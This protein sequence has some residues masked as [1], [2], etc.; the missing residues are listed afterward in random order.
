MPRT[1]SSH[2]ASPTRYRSPQRSPARRARSEDGS[3]YEMDLDALGMNSTFDSTGL[4]D[5]NA[6]RLD[7]VDSSDIEGPEDFTM[8]MTYWMTADLPLSQQIKSRKEV[9]VRV[10]EVSSDAKSGATDGQ[11]TTEEGDKPIMEEDSADKQS[12]TYNSGSPTVRANGTTD[13]QPDDNALSEFSMENEEKVMSYLSALPDSELPLATSTP[14]PNTLQV[15]KASSKARSL[16]PTVEDYTDTP[17]KPTQ[18]TVIHHV[19]ETTVQ[20]PTTQL[21]S[22]GSDVLRNLISALEARL[23]QREITSK[24]RIAELETILSFTRSEL[25]TARTEGYRQKEQLSVLREENEQR[26]RSEEG[27]KTLLETKLR[28]QERESNARMQEL[29]EELHLQN[30]AKLQNQQEEFERQLRASEEGRRS[31]EQEV[32]QSQHRVAQLQLELDGGS[33]SKEQ[34]LEDLK[35]THSAEQRKHDEAF[36]QERATLNQQLA[37]VQARADSL[38]VELEN[39]HHS[40]EHP[41][42]EQEFTVDRA[43]LNEKLFVL[44]NRANTLQSDLE[45]ANAEAQSAR[46]EAAATAALNR[47]T[48]DSAQTFSSRITELETRLHSL[49]S[50][51]NSSLSDISAKDQQLLHQIEDQERLEQQLNTAQGRIEGLETTISTLRQQLS[52]SHREAAKARTNAERFEREFEDITER[53]HDARLEADRR[54]ADVEKKLSKM[55]EQGIGTENRFKELKSEHEDVLESHTTALSEI[56]ETASDAVRKAGTLLEQERSEKRRLAKE[57]KTTTTA[58]ETLRTEVAQKA[59]AKQQESEDS[60]E[61]GISTLSAQSNTK[62]IEIENLRALLRKQAKDMKTL[63]SRN[64]SL[65]RENEAKNNIHTELFE[66]REINSSLKTQVATLQLETSTV[67]EENSALREN[68]EKVNKQIDER[69]AGMLKNLVKERARSVVRKRDEQWVETMGE[70]RD[71]KEEREIIGRVLMRE[72]GRQECGVAREE[73]GEKQ[74]YRFKYVKRAS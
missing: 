54:V 37:S 69:L 28:E 73:E 2:T 74:G 21:D 23:E 49:Q 18:G 71:L 48:A 57:L 45:K 12:Q 61:E 25:D 62:D 72:W 9:G 66:L 47:S 33:L 14:R 35:R 26:R 59:A 22:T 13:S 46:Q 27:S 42:P 51:L 10:E 1:R 56:R 41:R 6:P 70:F 50:Q 7:Q 67:R 36:R 65:R 29:G 44:Q 30:L 53:L 64:S 38:Q 16:Q 3:Q 52:D 40:K 8:N 34:E 32:L 60:A 31:A 19:H 39:A 15:P 43:A 63:K 55:K 68:A 20:E 11:D 24:T 17:R 58:L 5:S 4:D